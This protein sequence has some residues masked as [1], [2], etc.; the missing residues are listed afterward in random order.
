[1]RRSRIELKL[2][3]D[4]ACRK[5]VTVS[6]RQ[7]GLLKTAHEVSVLCDVDIGLIIFS[8][9]R[10]LFDYCSQPQR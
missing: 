1:M 3:E 2:I 4:K 9:T 10:E 7:A 8:S 5:L 6:K